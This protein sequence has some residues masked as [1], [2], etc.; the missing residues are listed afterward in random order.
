[1]NM[2]SI[3][4]KQFKNIKGDEDIYTYIDL[5]LDVIQESGLLNSTNSFNKKDII[6]SYDEQAIKN[7]II[8]IFNTIPGERIIRPTFGCNLLGYLF[9]SVSA[10]TAK[11]IGTT[12]LRAIE[13]W[14]PRVKVTN[15]EIAAIIDQ[16]TYEL[17]IVVEIPVLK[18]RDVR[19][20]GIL[21]RQGFVENSIV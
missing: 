7:S 17:E 20:I 1:M 21:S 10:Q 4:F 16:Q 2:S 11:E 13:L 18:K 14:E 3:N 9:R 8:N 19:I 5:H 6:M 15:I 12:V